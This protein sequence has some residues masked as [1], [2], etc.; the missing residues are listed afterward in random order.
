MQLIYEKSSKIELNT[1]ITIK[2][3]HF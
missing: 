3:F 1:L 2:Y